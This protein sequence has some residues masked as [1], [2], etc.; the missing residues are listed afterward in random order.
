MTS[1]NLLER[2]NELSDG[3]IR[4]FSATPAVERGPYWKF[5]LAPDHRIRRRRR[6]DLASV[7]AAREVTGPEQQMGHALVVYSPKESRR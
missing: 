3:M 4:P 6:T 7:A 1:L 2:M 5:R